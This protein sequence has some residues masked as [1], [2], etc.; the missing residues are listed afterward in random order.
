MK[1]RLKELNECASRLQ[2]PRKKFSFKSRT[3]TKQVDI[4][5]EV[6]PIVLEAS[7]DLSGLQACSGLRLTGNNLHHVVDQQQDASSQNTVYIVD[8]DSSL[9]DCRN[10]IFSSA[11]VKNVKN[12][13]IILGALSGSIHIEACCASVVAVGCHQFRMHESRDTRVYL[14]VTSHP[15]IEDCNGISVGPY[16]SSV[17]ASEAEFTAKLI[18]SHLDPLMNSYA[19]M[20]DFNWLKQQASPNWHA[21]T[22]EDSI[23][24]LGDSALATFKSINNI[25]Y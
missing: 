18:N 13:V 16:P 23:A 8:L 1:Q 24:D 3:K 4:Q 20:E 10:A 9:I 22:I 21:V 15:I 2:A 5:K 12:S 7:S 25:S 17:F 6:E 19:Q 11:Y 14:H